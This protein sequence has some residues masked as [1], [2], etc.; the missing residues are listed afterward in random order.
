M[1]QSTPF[2][3]RIFEI[4]MRMRETTRTRDKLSA[5]VCVGERAMSDLP[6]GWEKRQSR[7]SGRE[8]YYNIYTDASV[9]ERPV[10]PPP[11]HVREDTIPQFS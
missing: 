9:W 2:F 8:Y 11:G 10:A 1:C 6:A 3:I 5:R 4:E 7:S